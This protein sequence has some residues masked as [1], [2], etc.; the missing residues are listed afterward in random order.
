MKRRTPLSIASGLCA[1]STTVLAS[2]VT[3]SGRR[4]VWHVDAG[5][6]VTAST[7]LQANSGPL[8]MFGG[9]L[10]WG[11][12]PTRTI[13]ADG[14][15]AGSV[16][17]IEWTTPVA[18]TIRSIELDAS[19]D[20]PG[21]PSDRTFRRF[22]LLA[23]SSDFSGFDVILWDTDVVTP[24]QYV[25]VKPRILTARL[26]IPFTGRRFRAEFFQ[27]RTGGNSGPRIE[28]LAGYD[29]LLDYANGHR[30][31]RF[32][33]WTYNHTAQSLQGNPDSD[34]LGSPVWR[35]SWIVGGGGLGSPTPWFIQPSTPLLWQ[36]SWFGNT[37]I[38][39]YYWRRGLNQNPGVNR[40][41]LNQGGDTAPLVT[42]QNPLAEAA[43]VRVSGNAVIRP[44]PGQGY[45]G[46]VDWVVARLRRATVTPW[47]IL[48]A[49]T[50]SIQP[51]TPQLVAID[52]TTCVGSLDEIAFSL[53][54]QAAPVGGVW[55]DDPNV[56]LTLLR[57][58]VTTS[59]PCLGQPMTLSVAAPGSGTHSFVWR[60]NAIPI[61]TTAGTYS[62]INS[63]NGRTSSLRISRFDRF[64][65]ES[66]FDCLVMTD[67]GPVRSLQLSPSVCQ[68]DLNC[69]RI[70]TDSDFEMFA[71][72]YDL[73]ICD[74]P[75]M[76][77]ECPA[78]L[79]GD[80]LVSDSDFSIF[81]RAYDRLLC[82]ESLTAPD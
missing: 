27:T 45:V 33:D 4:N 5:L 67:C 2:E 24:Y 36:T 43:F 17:A 37:G 11:P 65:Y 25:G 57:P 23:S 55:L 76:P 79:D 72:A 39:W 7:P 46:G 70:V 56:G 12:E 49:G 15:P 9:S 61:D 10:G 18:S 52:T 20:E 47:S 21:A 78:D 32:A 60:R 38:D 50:V 48:A 63:P 42:W 13:F 69:D 77:A 58:T 71:F 74:D 3:G 82:E 68:G 54:E 73:L 6:T 1:I 80:S 51:E 29:Q 53:R 30:W 62:V 31:N 41:G 19:G 59:P 8:G 75:T 28:R 81:A 64:L 40:T 16:S 34:S 22:R 14:F 35:Y 44:H 66:S 26:P